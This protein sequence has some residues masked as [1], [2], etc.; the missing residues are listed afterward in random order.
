MWSAALPHQL[1]LYDEQWRDTPE[2]SASASNEPK[3]N[4]QTVCLEKFWL[5]EVNERNKGGEVYLP[6]SFPSSVSHWSKFISWKVNFSTLLV[7]IVWPFWCL[8]RMLDLITCGVRFR[9]N[10]EEAVESE[11][12]G[13]WLLG[14]NAWQ[15]SRERVDVPRANDWSAPGGANTIWEVGSLWS[16]CLI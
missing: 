13:M 6:R 9:L 16:L 4:L 10:P 11:T 3:G 14:P 7:C 15:L 8:L 12:P 1:L 5:R 2:C